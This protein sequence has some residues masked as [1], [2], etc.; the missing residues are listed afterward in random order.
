MLDQGLGGQQS[1]TLDRLPLLAE[2]GWR[3]SAKDVGRAADRAELE[4]LL[5][6]RA[7]ALLLV[8]PA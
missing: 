1:L 2:L 5:L 8:P 7:P 3:R 4:A 6:G